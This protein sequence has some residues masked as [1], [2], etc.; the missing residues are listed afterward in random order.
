[1]SIT[2]SFILRL[3]LPG[4]RK[5]VQLT[6]LRLNAECRC[7]CHRKVPRSQSYQDVNGTTVDSQNTRLLLEE[8]EQALLASQETI[9]VFLFFHFVSIPLKTISVL[10]KRAM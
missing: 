9:Q 4:K 2:Q 10:R 6:S 3:K 7:S 5:H 1:M 8:K